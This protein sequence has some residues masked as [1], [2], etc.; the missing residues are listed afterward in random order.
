MFIY[1]DASHGWPIY[2]FDV[3][4]VFLHGDLSKEVYIGQPP[5]FVAQREYGKVCRLK[6]SLY[7]LK[8]SPQAWFRSFSKVVI[9]FGMKK[10]DHDHSVFYKQLN[11]VCVL[12]TV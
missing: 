10:S 12:L 1:I 4:S 3:K 8:Q 11:V 5:R 2:Q 9:E 7:E 6:K